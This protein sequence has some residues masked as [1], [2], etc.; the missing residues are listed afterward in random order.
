[1]GGGDDAEP[2]LMN[3][4]EEDKEQPL[5]ETQERHLKI[6]R[7]IIDRKFDRMWVTAQ[8]KH[9]IQ[10][11][12]SFSVHNHGD[13]VFVDGNQNNIEVL[14]KRDLS[15][16]GSIKTENAQALS[17]SLI[18]DNKL[19]AGCQ[20]KRLQV[21]EIDTSKPKEIGSLTKLKEI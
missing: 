7:D 15:F 16:I 17:I 5:D 13:I 10:G 6:A 12:Y 19:F 11:K 1:L 3:D 20:G 9:P 2:F 18:A 21:F 8:A 4:V 14:N